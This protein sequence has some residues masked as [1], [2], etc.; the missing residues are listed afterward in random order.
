MVLVGFGWWWFVFTYGQ[1]YLFVGG[2]LCLLGG[3]GLVF[4]CR[5][6][7]CWVWHD[8]V[9]PHLGPVYIKTR[10]IETFENT[11]DIFQYQRP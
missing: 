6:W 8:M 11:S 3:C 10:I 7:P 2:D 1:S 9:L 4:G 5:S